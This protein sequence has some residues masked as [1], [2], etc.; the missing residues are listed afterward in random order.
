[1]TSKDAW[2][3]VA[4]HT[5]HT[6]DEDDADYS[7]QFYCDECDAVKDHPRCGDC[8]VYFEEAD[9]SICPNCLEKAL[10]ESPNVKERF[11]ETVERIVEK[12]IYVK[13]NDPRSQETMEEFEKRIMG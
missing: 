12:P 4:C 2:N 10:N 5:Q 9:I 3:C 11:I 7:D 8:T 6:P 13:D 1:M